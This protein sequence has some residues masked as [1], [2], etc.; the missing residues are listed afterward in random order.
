M[1]QF[2]VKAFGMKEYNSSDIILRYGNEF[3]GISLKKKPKENA[4]LM[5]INFLLW[6][7]H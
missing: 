7:I 6:N 3:V 2:Q 5:L 1:E 4:L